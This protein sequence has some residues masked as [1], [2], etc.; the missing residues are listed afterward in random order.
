MIFL[1]LYVNSARPDLISFSFN[2][3]RFDRILYLFF[4]S[5]VVENVAKKT[6]SSM[7]LLPS[8]VNTR[9]EVVYTSNPFIVEPPFLLFLRL[10]SFRASLSRMIMSLG[11]TSVSGF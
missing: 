6:A 8:P 9:H 10:F 7:P 1:V 3:D 11:H 5:V 2:P 4:V